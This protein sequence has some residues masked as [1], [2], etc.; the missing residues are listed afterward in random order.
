MQHF[1]VN[2]QAAKAATMEC[3]RNIASATGS[4][5]RMNGD[6]RPGLQGTR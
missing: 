2:G 5:S 3:G 4:T 6:S 1:L